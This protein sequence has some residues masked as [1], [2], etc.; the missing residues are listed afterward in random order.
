MSLIKSVS[1]CLSLGLLISTMAMAS[2]LNDFPISSEPAQKMSESIN[3]G[4]Q[5]DDHSDTDQQ[6][7]EIAKLIAGQLS[8]TIQN[9]CDMVISENDI[10]R[11]SPLFR[12]LLVGVTMGVWSDPEAYFTNTLQSLDCPHAAS[13]SAVLP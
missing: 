4:E 10:I 13:G 3:S 7:F 1:L 12:K 2:S 5:H 8:K 6:S 9:R 11:N